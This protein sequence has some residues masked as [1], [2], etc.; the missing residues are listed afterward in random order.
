MP[1]VPAS[2]M[3]SDAAFPEGV[4]WIR[5][6]RRWSGSGIAVCVAGVLLDRLG[7]RQ[8]LTGILLG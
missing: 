7:A 6:A 4:S 8:V 2:R 1:L 5:Y 3:R